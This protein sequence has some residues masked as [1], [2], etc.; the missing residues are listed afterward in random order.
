[1]YL[2]IL[3]DYNDTMVVAFWL[4]DFLLTIVSGDADVMMDFMEEVVDEWYE[5]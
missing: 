2:E 4:N 3:A 5:N 1:M